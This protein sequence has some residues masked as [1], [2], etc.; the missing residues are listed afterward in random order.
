M[1]RDAPFPSWAGGIF[2]LEERRLKKVKGF[3]LVELIVVI[4]IIGVLAAILIPSMLGYVRKAKI[5]TMNTNAK[6]LHD[7]ATTALVEL[8]SEGHDITGIVTVSWTNGTPTLNGVDVSF[9]TKVKEYF[10]KVSTLSTAQV[11][12]EGMACTAAYCTDGNYRGGYPVGATTQNYSTFT[13]N[14]AK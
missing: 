6:N 9:D 7:A 12:I 11:L 4:A 2:R 14:D 3:T 10:D 13:L 5:T 8:D 1:C